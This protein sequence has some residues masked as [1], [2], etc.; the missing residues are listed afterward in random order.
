MG[1]L[2][3]FMISHRPGHSAVPPGGVEEEGVGVP[4]HTPDG[5]H[6]HHLP[7]PHLHQSNTVNTADKPT[8]FRD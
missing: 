3:N 5:L 7:H 6:P 8:G 2:Y 4:G 1:T